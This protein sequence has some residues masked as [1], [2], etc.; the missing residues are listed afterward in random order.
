MSDKLTLKQKLFVEAYLRTRNGYESAK[1]AGYS[2]DDNTLRVV[3]CENLTK[4]NIRAEIDTRLK[5]LI[6]SATQVLTGLSEIATADIAEV[7]E[8]DGSFSLV[9][10]KKRGV[11]KLIKSISFDKDTGRVTKV[12]VYSAHEGQRDMA[13]YHQLMPTTVKLVPMDEADQVIDDAAK[14]H[15]LP[16]P[17]GTDNQLDK[18]AS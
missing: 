14:A 7:F 12:E 17:A 15:G 9:E 10:A 8:P 3:A 6:L 2:G 18:P 5:P 4:P 1:L 16:L 11:S 13:K